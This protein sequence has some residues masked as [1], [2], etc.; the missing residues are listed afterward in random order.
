MDCS[1]QFEWRVFRNRGPCHRD[2][3]SREFHW[4]VWVLND[5]TISPP[6]RLDRFDSRGC[7]KEATACRKISDCI[8]DATLRPV[9]LGSPQNLFARLWTIHEQTGQVTEMTGLCRACS[10]EALAWSPAPARSCGVSA[11]LVRYMRE[12]MQENRRQLT[13]LNDRSIQFS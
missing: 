10:A 12:S 11:P 8:C 13:G 6:P 3:C 2:I 4:E 1:C 7:S 9:L 5:A